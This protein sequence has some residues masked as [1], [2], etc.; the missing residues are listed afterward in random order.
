MPYRNE[1]AGE[2]PRTQALFTGAVEPAA[3]QDGH[4]SFIGMTT[5]NLPPLTTSRV[6]N[7]SCSR[8]GP[9]TELR[10]KQSSLQRPPSHLLPRYLE[11]GSRAEQPF[12]IATSNPQFAPRGQQWSSKDSNRLPPEQW[13]RRRHKDSCIRKPHRDGRRLRSRG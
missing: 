10:Q 9:F 6:R 12:W 11:S 2:L 3:A 8:P 7:H 5:A 1:T 4:D 13:L